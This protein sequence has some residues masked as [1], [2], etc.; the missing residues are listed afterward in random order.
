MQY[1]TSSTER[2]LQSTN[3][4]SIPTISKERVM[5]NLFV[6]FALLTVSTV[7]A[8][9]SPIPNPGFESWSGSPSSP[10]GWVVANTPGP[11]PIASVFPVNDVHSGALAARGAVIFFQGA[12]V[13]S[14][15][16]IAGADGAGFPISV[17]YEAL[18]GWYKYTAVG[19]DGLSI[20]SALRLGRTTVGAGFLL[21]GLTTQT[22]Y[23]EFVIPHTFV[24]SSVPDTGMIIITIAGGGT[25]FHD[26]SAY[27]VDDLS[28]G[29]ATDVKENG[30]AIPSA[31]ALEQN[32]PNPFN[33]TT[34]IQFSI[35]SAQFVTLKVY[36]VIGQE[37]ATLANEQL[38][39]GNYR[40]EFDAASLPSGTYIYRLSTPGFSSV[41]KMSLVK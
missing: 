33:P 13:A 7:F 29:P 32:F 17:R 15:Q 40:A 16:M 31:F 9:N 34:K 24:N 6:G 19:G 21:G 8:Q 35:P 18:R 41:K 37:V 30:T 20:T 39:A 3:Q 25:T 14:G 36:N 22:V 5:K 2:K 11:P 1:K 4:H 23:R 26:G 28:Y 10:N 38:E 27:I 12:P